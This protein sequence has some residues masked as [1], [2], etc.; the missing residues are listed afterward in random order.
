M[1]LAD[2]GAPPPPPLPLQVE[3]V[4]LLQGSALLADDGEGTVDSSHPTDLG[5]VQHA[6]AFEAALQPL[7]LPAPVSPAAAK[8]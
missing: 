2:G 1:V 8:L 3:G 6:D 7:L 5:F 4:H